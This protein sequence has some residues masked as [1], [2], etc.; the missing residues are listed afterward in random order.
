MKAIF[1]MITFIATCVY[2]N[3]PEG[4]LISNEDSKSI[5]ANLLEGDVAVLNYN[6]SG[7]FSLS[8]EKIIFIKK[9]A[10]ITAEVYLDNKLVQ[11]KVLTKKDINY[12]VDFEKKIRL[13]TNKGR[14]C[15]T[16]ETYSILLNNKPEFS[17]VDSSCSWNGY[18]LLKKEVFN[19]SIN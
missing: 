11:S 16:S 6:M 13:I 18:S 5:F 10:I 4:K 3:K 17:V 15:T 2:T 9:N 7:C 1:L 12:L 8:A 14:I 19:I